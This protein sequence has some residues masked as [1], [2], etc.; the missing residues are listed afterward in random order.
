MSEMTGM[1]ERMDGPGI[2]GSRAAGAV[3]CRGR[4][5]DRR[6]RGAVPGN[7]P[8]VAVPAPIQDLGR[9]GVVPVIAHRLA[10]SPVADRSIEKRQHET[11]PAQ[12]GA[13]AL[14]VASTEELQ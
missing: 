6:R 5:C 11:L 2:A 12:G 10:T 1:V 9:A 13:H 4:R 7:R 8:V 14:L 3:A